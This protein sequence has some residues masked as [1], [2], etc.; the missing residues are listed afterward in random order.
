MTLSDLL[1]I[2]SERQFLATCR[3]YLTLLGCG[4][5]RNVYR[6]NSRQVIKVAKHDKGYT[7]N[8]SECDVYDTYG[9]LGLF[10]DIVK[11]ADS[12]L[13]VIQPMAEPLTNDDAEFRKI[14]ELVYHI[15]QSKEYSTDNDFLS[16][17]Q[18][19]LKETEWKYLLDFKKADSFGRIG[20]ELRII[21]YGMNN[22]A[23]EEYFNYGLNKQRN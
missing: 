12:Y 21:D 5:S 9:G 2:K 15:E 3:E 19:F 6:L 14:C 1:C 16:K 22:E 10:A 7:Q 17:L 20:N 18:G 11:R 4:T 23:F 13:W 8:A